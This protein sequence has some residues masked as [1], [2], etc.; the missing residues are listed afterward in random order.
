MLN[1]IDKSNQPYVF[2][3]QTQLTAAE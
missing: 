1:T 3:S 2:R